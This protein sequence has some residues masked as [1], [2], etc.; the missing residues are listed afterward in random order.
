MKKRRFV[1]FLA[2]LSLF[3]VFPATTSGAPGLEVPTAAQDFSLHICA[4][5]D[6]CYKPVPFDINKYISPE[7]DFLVP[8]YSDADG[9][10]IY[11]DD[12][13]VNLLRS[14]DHISQTNWS[15]TS[16]G[17]YKNC[18]YNCGF[19]FVWEGHALRYNAYN[20]AQH[21]VS[22]TI[23]DYSAYTSHTPGS[24]WLTTVD[25]HYKACIHCSQVVN[26]AAHS[27]TLIS[28]PPF[29]IY[30]CTVCGRESSF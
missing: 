20:A 14:C 18:V 15:F 6:G 19:Q 13:D 17:H 8:F 2:I 23:C 5:G 27:W 1:A 30:R 12:F 24:N 16:T 25:V 4:P 10:I 3:F 22:C 29:V 7:G 11:A 26:Q 9:K 21:L 28:P